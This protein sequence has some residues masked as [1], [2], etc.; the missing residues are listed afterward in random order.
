[1]TLARAAFV[2]LALVGATTFGASSTAAASRGA[3][4]VPYPN[5]SGVRVEKSTGYFPGIW[6]CA[7]QQAGRVEIIDLNTTGSADL[8]PASLSAPAINAT[9]C[10]PGSFRGAPN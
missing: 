5:G 7:P 2:G 1:M 8:P 9:D 6:V 4:V 3:D 10:T